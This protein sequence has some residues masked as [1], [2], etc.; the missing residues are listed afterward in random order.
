MNVYYIGSQ[1]MGCNYVRNLLPM[2]HNG[3]TG[4][5]DSLYRSR[6]NADWAKDEILKSDI[7]VF[8]RADTVNHH[9]VALACKEAGKLT[10]FDNDDTFKQIEDGFFKEL[11]KQNYMEN[12]VKVNRLMDNFIRNV[13]L[14][15]TTTEFL[16][17]EY[18]ELNENVVVLPNCVDPMDWSTPKRN[19]TD[20]IRIGIV[21]SVAY[22][23]DVA[24]ISDYIKELSHRKDITLVLFGLQS[25]KGRKKNK[26]IANAFE[27]E[28]ALWDEAN[29]EHTPWCHMFEY[30]DVLNNLELDMML[31]P[32]KDNY[33][34]RCKSNLKFLEAAMCEIP[35]IAQSF[36]DGLSPYDKD[37][38][39]KN[40]ILATTK[41]DFIRETER[42]I[43][44]KELRRKIG[45]EAH[46]YVLANYDINNNY[47]KW[48]KAYQT[49]WKKES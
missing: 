8:H 2:W 33:F 42:L 12:W 31:I 27:K 24:E 35:V 23:N 9:K 26:L 29:I 13:D 43:K 32:R 25:K 18:R 10:V 7:I 15:T 14:V 16:A 38:N 49:I 34:N 5:V 36:P 3:W 40:G 41:E 21:G 19:E 1:Y 46:K 20:K 22:Y 44:D 48:Q 30:F 28:Y 37:L 45:K 11:D 39:G 6:K 17:K 4:D 47:L